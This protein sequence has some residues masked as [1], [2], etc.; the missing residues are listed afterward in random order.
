M[1]PTDNYI[2]F[3]CILDFG[4]GS[5][6]MELSKEL[7]G[8]EGTVFLGRGTVRAEW[9]H[10]LGAYDVRKEIFITIIDKG[11][12]NRM[13]EAM[14]KKFNLDKS[15]NGIAFSIPLK[16]LSKEICLNNESNLEKR[17]VNKMN[18]ECIF[19]IVDK[20][21]SGDVLEAAET[22][23]SSG[24][25][26]IHGRGTGTQEKAV[27]FNIKIE[28]EKDIVLIL[29]NTEQSESIVNAIKDR[30]KICDPGR[31]IVFVMDVNKAI[32]LYQN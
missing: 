4:K 29:A 3:S 7:G 15:G 12:E 13:Y 17:G 25:T 26:V 31:G 18:Y 30:L 5:K 20:G 16:Y 24:G 27:L 22:A 11:L 28:P 6:A 1:K 23:G 9:L 19:T 32:G 10:K 8:I 21:F 2:L 14:S